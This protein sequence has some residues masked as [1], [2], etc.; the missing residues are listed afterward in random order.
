MLGPA[1]YVAAL[2][3]YLTSAVVV[4]DVP[5]V[6][7]AGVLAILPSIWL[8]I[9]IRRPSQLLTWFI[10]L[11]VYLP[12]AIVPFY[13]G[14]TH[15]RYLAYVVI[16]A[17]VFLGLS[18]A[19]HLPVPSLA[20]VRLDP[21]LF[22]S[23]LALVVTGGYLY[24]VSVF[25]VPLRLPSLAEVYTVRDEYKDVLAAAGGLAAYVV[26]WLANAVNPFLIAYG[27]VRRRWPLVV[28]ACLAQL[29]IFSLGSS[30]VVLLSGIMLIVLYAVL[31]LARPIVALVLAWSVPVIILTAAIAD[32]VLDTG[33]L[34]SLFVR[35][36]LVLPAQLTGH[37]HD[38]FSSHPP[39]LLGDSILRGIT[40]Y[41]Y[42]TSIA[43]VIGGNYFGDPRVHANANLFA[44]AFAQ[45]S[46]LGI[47]LF[48]LLFVAVLW[49]FDVAGRG[50]P[51]AFSGLMVAVPALWLS[52]SGLLTSILTHG[53]ALSVLLLLLAPS[54]RF[55]SGLV[56]RREGRRAKVVHLS[57]VHR[58]HDTRILHRECATLAEAGYEVVLVAQSA[59]AAANVPPGVRI[60]S[61]PP[62][63]T[64]LARVLRTLPRLTSIAVR[65][66][67]DVY[68]LHDSELLPIGLILKALGA[69]VLYDAHED[70]PRQIAYKHWIRPSLRPLVARLAATVEMLAA[71]PLDAVV[72]ATPDIATRF[73]R[74]ATVVQNFPAPDELVPRRPTPYGERP[75]VVAY[76][77]GITAVRGAAEMVEAMSLVGAPGARLVMA[78]GFAPAGL[79]KDLATR[80]ERGRVT[81]LGWQERDG[82]ADVL[83]AARVGLVLFH[84]TPNYLA[85][86]PIKMFEYM[87][88]GIPVIGSD[89]PLWRELVSDVGAGI[90][91]D[92]LE[93]AAI[94]AAIDRLLLDPV[95][96]EEM[97]RR[98]QQAVRERYHWGSQ[99]AE[100][101]GLYETLTADIGAMAGR[102]PRAPAGQP[103]VPSTAAARRQ[104]RS[105]T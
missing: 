72:A 92:P 104:Q 46:Y 67:G 81:F 64:R 4:I 62:P 61:I 58:A 44:N 21:R 55:S 39:A 27:L 23:A 56:R 35:R 66:R 30:K 8:P 102:I 14:T 85:A 97:G 76:V 1:A 73:G 75:P 101:L 40:P 48:G 15:P 49:A 53:L 17:L 38:F 12:S 98:G 41:S 54:R 28:A 20:R 19:S 105:R 26:S 43:V 47:P 79:Q 10:Y 87:A 34:T 103:G 99:A 9:R 11:L 70:L 83:D 25:G 33:V 86:Y 13:S 45:F 80:D 90:L 18:L 6:L 71:R 60:V 89:F 68:H 69:R 63:R 82:V 2:H 91:V 5:L 95:A 24:T 52:N 65:E 37:Y 57:S 7:V 96:A 74:R 29:Y 3:L 100:L 16:L 51:L 42:D 36:L 32:R 88:V 22:W 93:P 94:A 59:M 77:G 31:R 50:R 78:G 84:P